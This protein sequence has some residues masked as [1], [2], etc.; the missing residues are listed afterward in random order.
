MEC[1]DAISDESPS[2]LDGTDTQG[3]W[4][5]QSQIG[6]EK[7]GRGDDPVRCT[8]RPRSNTKSEIVIAR[9]CV[10]FRDASYEEL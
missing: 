6:C 2:C 4:C 10:A 7:E 3:K 5:G 1:K 9:G 8:Q